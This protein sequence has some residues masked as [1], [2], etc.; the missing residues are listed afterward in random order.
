VSCARRA[1]LFVGGV[2]FSTTEGAAAA[3]GAVPAA[4]R[5]RA[6]AQLGAPRRRLRRRAETLS[7]HFARYGDLADCFLMADK[8]TGRPRGFGFVTYADPAV[9]QQVAAGA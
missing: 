1:K 3:L 8:T 7:A 4:L 6:D 2:A 5:R 9:A